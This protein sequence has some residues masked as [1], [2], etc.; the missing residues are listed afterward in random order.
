MANTY[1]LLDKNILSSTQTSITFTGLGSYSANYTDLLF[2][3]SIR[4]DWST[5]NNDQFQLQFNGDT[6]ASYPHKTVSGTGSGLDWDGGTTTSINPQAQTSNSTSNTFGSYQ[7]YIPNYS[8]SNKKS[9]SVDGV[10]ENNG[11]AV[12]TQLGAYLW[13]NT[14]AITSALFKT[15][16]NIGFLANSSFY[17]YG[18]KKN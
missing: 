10:T 5:D 11:T 6:T 14:A 16:R 15:S 13:D 7:F 2:V 4:T 17:L 1:T 9:V 18:I 8:S 3:T 12:F